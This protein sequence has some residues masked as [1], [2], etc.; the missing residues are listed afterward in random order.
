MKPNFSAAAPASHRHGTTD[1]AGAVVDIYGKTLTAAD[2]NSPDFGQPKHR[3]DW[4]A[5]RAYA[6]T[7]KTTC[8][9]SATRKWNGKRWI[10]KPKHG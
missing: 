6:E 5:Q 10:V 8:R 4:F 3:H 2:V 7:V 9:C 1:H